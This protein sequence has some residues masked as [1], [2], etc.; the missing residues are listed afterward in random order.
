MREVKRTGRIIPF[1]AFGVAQRDFEVGGFTVPEGAAVAW[2]TVASHTEPKVAPYAD[3]GRFDPSRFARGEGSAP[4]TFAPQG[5][6][7][8][9]TSHR[10]AGVEY[11]AV[12]LQ[13]FFSE[14]LRGG[15][16]HLP[17]PAPELVT[18]GIPATFAGGLT[19]TFGHASAR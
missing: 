15:S 8:A 9:Y 18:K 2:T 17:G 16:F 14:L 3:A 1:T 4:H 11:S 5:P 12:V 13:V 7:E 19:V 10:C 6:G